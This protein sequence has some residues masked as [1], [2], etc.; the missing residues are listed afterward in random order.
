MGSRTSGFLDPYIHTYVS[1]ESKVDTTLRRK[2]SVIQQASHPQTSSLLALKKLLREG[3]RRISFGL[4][5]GVER[6]LVQL[7]KRD[8]LAQ[9]EW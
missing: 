2:G 3:V 1:C 6:S 7:V 5:R 4:E 8:V 9:S